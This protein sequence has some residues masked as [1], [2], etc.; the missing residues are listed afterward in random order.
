M[1]WVLRLDI[2]LHLESRVVPLM[3]RFLKEIWLSI[4][5]VP[6]YLQS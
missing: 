1:H 4:L 2:I 5:I 3:T 6:V